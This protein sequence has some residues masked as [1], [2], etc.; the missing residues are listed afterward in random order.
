MNSNPGATPSSYITSGAN[1]QSSF[2]YGQALGGIG[3]S[4]GAGLAQ[5]GQSMVQ[6]ASYGIQ[7][8]DAFVGAFS[9]QVQQRASRLQG[10]ADVLALTKDFN[11][12]MASDAVMGAA[13]NRKGGSVAAVASAAQ[14]Q[15]DWDKDFTE[16]ST[17]IAES[18]YKSQYIAEMGR[19]EQAGIAA[20]AAKKIGMSSAIGSTLS[21]VGS[22]LY[23]IGG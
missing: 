21:S 14:S 16:M 6:S 20:D 2:S 15:Y 13:Q 9:A 22:S 12:S 8:N 1:R 23:S 11:K 5:Y 7:Q 3:S 17:K 10:K 4:I 18:G 19:A